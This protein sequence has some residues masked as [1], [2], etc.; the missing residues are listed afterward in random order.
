M[1]LIVQSPSFW[2]LTFLT[3]D[4][5]NPLDSGPGWKEL[6]NPISGLTFLG[7]ALLLTVLMV[8]VLEHWNMPLFG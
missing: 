7:I 2:V 5:C 4:G 1:F 8:S 3:E 6:N